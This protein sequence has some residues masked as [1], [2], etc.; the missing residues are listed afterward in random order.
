[1]KINYLGVILVVL[2]I[3][4]G[5][6]MYKDSDSFNLRCVISKVDGNTYCVRERSKLELAADLLAEATSNM[7]KLVKYVG[8]NHASNPAV[9]RLVENFNPDKISET[10][11][12]SE[13]TAYSENKGEKM[14]F[15]LN[16]DKQGTRLIDLSTLTF[17][18]IHELAHLMTASIGHKDEFW[19]NFKFLLNSAKKSGIYEPIDYSKSPVQYCGT[20]IDE[21]PFY[22]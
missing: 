17:V 10:L 22:K 3:C 5:F 2:M 1:M 4:F 21:N 14:A 13:H 9:K 20:R 11:P 8:A 18:A 12:T 7:K 15:C 19:D 6:K 16:E